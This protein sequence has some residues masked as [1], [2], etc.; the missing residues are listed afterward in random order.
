MAFAQEILGTDHTPDGTWPDRHFEV[1]VWVESDV[2]R[3]GAY[4]TEFVTTKGTA[5]AAL[6]IAINKIKKQLDPEDE[7]IP[8][9]INGV[10]A[11]DHEIREMDQDEWVEMVN[12]EQE[13]RRQRDDRER[14]IVESTYIY[15]AFN[16]DGTRR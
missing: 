14:Q 12:A 7:S 16:P 2:M 15:D 9:L 10:L 13:F 8:G 1:A 5:E 11:T 4:F 3:G 6:R